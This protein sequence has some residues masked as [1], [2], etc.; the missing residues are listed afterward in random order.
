MTRVAYLLLCLLIFLEYGNASCFGWFS[1]H[2][3]NDL[4][5]D[6][7]QAEDP[8]LETPNPDE[9]KQ[10]EQK[11]GEPKPDVQQEPQEHH[12][13]QHQEQHQDQH[14]DQPQEQVQQ[15][16]EQQLV[17]QQPVGQHREQLQQ[18]Q[19]HHAAASQNLPE[20]DDAS[21]DSGY[22]SFVT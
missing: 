9:Q 7:D 8:P 19:I 4:L 22:T 10:D 11:P 16:V 12:Q 14:Q 6:D 18:R 15:P 13:Q 20:L 1:K 21:V 3:E 17:E 5:H 2:D